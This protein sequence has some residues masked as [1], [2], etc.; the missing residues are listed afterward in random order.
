M[1]A[2][3]VPPVTC[4][5]S[6]VPSRRLIAVTVGPLPMYTPSSAN[7]TDDCDGVPERAA[8]ARLAS[9]GVDGT[10]RLIVAAQEDDAVSGGGRRLSSDV[11]PPELA[12][13]FLARTPRVP[14]RPSPR[15]RR[16]VQSR[17]L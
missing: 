7:V 13:L 16:P 15:I 8:P 14:A 11:S 17:A 9:R 4:V 12:F 1:S 5:Q 2:V 10:Y 6:V 3:T